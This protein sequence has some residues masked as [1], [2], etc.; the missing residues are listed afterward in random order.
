MCYFS[1]TNK[2]IETM[3]DKKMSA[4]ICLAVSMLMSCRSGQNA[5]SDATVD[6]L[7]TRTQGEVWGFMEG[8]V[9]PSQKE[10]KF[11][12]AQIYPVGASIKSEGAEQQWQSVL[13][14]AKLD[15]QQVYLS[16]SFDQASVKAIINNEKQQTT[17]I[18]TLLGNLKERSANGLV[19]NF[20][21]IKTEDAQRYIKFIK[22]FADALHS[23]KLTLAVV[24]PPVNSFGE[25]DIAALSEASDYLLFDFST[26]YGAGSGQTT[27][28]PYAN[29]ERGV[30][31]DMKHI[32][33]APIALRKVMM[34]LP[35][36]DFNI[37]HGSGFALE[38][39]LAGVAVKYTGQKS[40]Q[41]L[42]DTLRAKFQYVDT[43][44]IR[45]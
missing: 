43:V 41:R 19:A 39:G 40:D 24:T 6:S 1:C 17:T 44:K 34:I 11:L 31:G 22:K 5:K 18:S 42:N 4:I 25:K 2:L 8:D 9:N 10:V 26:A 45:R 13:T 12:T 16:Q 21:L 3:I 36:N 15:S 32:L 23:Q 38:T 28:N 29:G 20:G 27:D 37:Q 33:Y 30:V 7:V 35:S 14:A